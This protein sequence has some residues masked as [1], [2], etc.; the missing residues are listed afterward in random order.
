M[1][2]NKVLRSSLFPTN[3]QPPKLNNKNYKS[4]QQVHTLRNVNVKKD[5]KDMKF[6]H[7][8]NTQ[9]DKYQTN[10]QTTRNFSNAGISGGTTNS[11]PTNNQPQHARK[12]GIKTSVQP[13]KN[14]NPRQPTKKASSNN[15]T[16]NTSM[17]SLMSTFSKN[18]KA[19]QNFVTLT[20]NQFSQ[21]LNLIGK[22]QENVSNPL[23]VISETEK[24]QEEQKIEDLVKQVEA[25]ANQQVESQAASNQPPK[26]EPKMEIPSKPEPQKPVSEPQPAEPSKPVVNTQI[27]MA[28][29]FTV[30]GD[31]APNAD[32]L[33]ERRRKAKQEWLAALEEQRLEQK[34]IRDAEKEKLKEVTRIEASWMNPQS[35]QQPEVQ[36]PAPS[37]NPTTNS[38]I[39]TKISIQAENQIPSIISPRKNQP[40]NQE[41]ESEKLGSRPHI[42]TGYVQNQ[43]NSGSAYNW[44]DPDE[45][46]KRRE[47]SRRQQQEALKQ[48]IAER[49]ALRD[50]LGNLEIF[51]SC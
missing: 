36:N 5:T 49:E 13:S 37:Q 8:A 10:T 3:T 27:T 30:G 40:R 48:Q 20:D 22:G 39:P 34:K 19:S 21:I 33:E 50:F 41:N 18:S 32:P 46:K 24:R 12:I 43:F 16:A 2:E 23:P 42:K 11:K 15:V 38:E 47:E 44:T 25:E 28:S 45:E 7:L 29:A 51:A 14:Q 26:S 1:P 31:G 6:R 17:T 9:Q 4:R 35:S